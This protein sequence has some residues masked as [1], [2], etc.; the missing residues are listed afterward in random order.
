MPIFR[1]TCSTCLGG[2]VADDIKAFGALIGY[3]DPKKIWVVSE[4]GLMQD[5]V[6]FIEVM[7]TQVDY[8]HQ[9]FKKLCDEVAKL[10]QEELGRS[11]E[12]ILPGGGPMLPVSFRPTKEGAE[13]YGPAV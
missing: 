12:V 8:G 1:V 6:G 10:L 13:I 2:D 11:F 4:S 9:N 3:D 5:D 7:V